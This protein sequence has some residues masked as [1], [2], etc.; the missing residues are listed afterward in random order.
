[1]NVV[2]AVHPTSEVTVAREIEL[3]KSALL[4]A[5]HVTLC[6]PVYEMLACMAAL[7]Q[8]DSD[9]QLQ[10]IADLV[11]MIQPENPLLAQAISQL[12]G[13]GPP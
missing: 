11:P 9:T 2:I 3:V 7:A 1:M 10:L 12:I 6:S 4:Y 13:K 8:S 5:D